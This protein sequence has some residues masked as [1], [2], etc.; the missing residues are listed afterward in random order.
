MMPENVLQALNIFL[1]PY[2][3]MIAKKTREKDQREENQS[4]RHVLQALNIFLCPNL[5]LLAKKT[6]Q[7]DQRE[8]IKEKEY[9]CKQ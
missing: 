4:G 1:Y 9:F 7:K 8:E 6:W 5:S 3:S 2:L